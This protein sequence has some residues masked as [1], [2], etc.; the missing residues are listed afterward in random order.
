MKV[1]LITSIVRGSEAR[2]RF[3]SRRLQPALSC[4]DIDF[5]KQLPRCAIVIAAA[6]LAPRLASSSPA[7]KGVHF[8]FAA[9]L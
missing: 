5:D 9:N 3:G 4:V 1:H 8:H 2:Q 6:T 7:V